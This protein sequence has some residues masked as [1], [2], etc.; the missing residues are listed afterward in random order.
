MRVNL[1][2]AILATGLGLSV[3]TAPA[4]AD[5]FK[6]TDANG[7]VTYANMPLQNCKKLAL[8]PIT[9]QPLPRPGGRPAA[10]SPSS[11][12]ATFPRVDDAAQKSR[13][14]DRK[15]LLEQEQASE[16]RELEAARKALSEQE[17]QIL[18]GER[19]V[20]GGINSARMLDR[21][22]PYRDKVGQHER[23][24]EALGKEMSNLR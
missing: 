12:P 10:S 7:H 13:D 5:I 8:D 21:L 14:Q 1:P 20:G 4:Q 22:Q 16:Q 24:L 18:P 15:R 23:N 17:S 19:N 9:T 2:M 3:T 6:C 11:S